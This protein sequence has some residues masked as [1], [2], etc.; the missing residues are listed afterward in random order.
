MTAL[1]TPR[2]SWDQ[3]PEPP[4][5]DRRRPGWQVVAAALVVMA[6]P[7]A[8][9]LTG[10]GWGAAA[11]WFLLGLALGGW[12][13]PRRPV[14]GFLP[15]PGPGA[16]PGVLVLTGVSAALVA[17]HH[18]LVRSFVPYGIALVLPVVTRWGNGAVERWAARFGH[19]VGHAVSYVLFTLL[20]LLT[21]V[22]PWTAQR[23]VRTDPLHTT[24]GWNRRQRRSLQAAQPWAPDAVVR[25]TSKVRR[26]L[27]TAVVLAV[28]AAVVVVT[29]ATRRLVGLDHDETAAAGFETTT[30]SLGDGEGFKVRDPVPEGVTEF[31]PDPDGPQ[32]AMQGASWFTGAFPQAQGWALNPRNAWRPVN[33]HR[34]RD[35][36][37]EYLNISNGERR[38]WAPPAGAA[39][40]LTVWLFGGSTT[41]GLD[42]RDDH[43]IASE[44]ARA[45]AANGIALDIHNKGQ[46]GHLHWMEAERFAWDLTNE[47]APD[48]VLFYDGVNEI[49]EAGT[50]NRLGTGDGKAMHD[51]TL[52]DAW[53]RSPAAQRTAPPAP[54]GAVRTGWTQGPQLALVDEAKATVDRYDRAR[55]LSR[56]T[57]AAHGI[58]VRYFWQPD[59]Y[60]RPIVMSEPHYSTGQE[61]R[62]RLAQQVRRAFLPKDVVDLSDSLRG[63]TE[64]LFTDDVH[65]NEEGARLIAAQM[66]TSIEGDLQ[67]LVA[68]KKGT[69]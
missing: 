33:V 65:H 42:Q 68:A 26:A 20:G 23:L 5:R 11:A 54:A 17:T 14:P 3:T 18:S 60:S 66:F 37:S 45:A 32:A 51:P 41:Y 69:P 22:L 34:L 30:N 27:T 1:A 57:A 25:R 12:V 35:F 52:L 47:P 58:P 7:V 50:L 28:V 9:G 56:A 2:P 15:G 48:L 62:S 61:N 64:P 24:Q 39:P 21:V 40:R 29:P 38:T 49:W 44:L 16:L 31:R 67:R 4:V 8:W 63:T 43:T 46:N 55:S 59:R 10:R 53:D 36:S 19:A 13:A 6:A